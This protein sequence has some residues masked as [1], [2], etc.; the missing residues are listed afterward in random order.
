MCACVRVFGSVLQEAM[1][2][3]PNR[4]LHVCA[5]DVDVDVDVCD[6]SDCVCVRDFSLSC[7]C[8]NFSL[9]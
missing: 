1:S 9:M 8:V 5:Y 2:T 4:H 7:H 6:V 3:C